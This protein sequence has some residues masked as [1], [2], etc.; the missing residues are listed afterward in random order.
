MTRPWYDLT[1]KVALVVGA[2]RGLG[3]EAALA[4]ASGGADVACA[5]RSELA[6]N[7]TVSEIEARGRRSIPL[8]LDAADERSLEAGINQVATAWGDLDVLVFAAGVMHASR[9]GDTSVSDWERV[10]RTNL[11]GAFVAARATERHMQKRGGRMIFFSTAF[12]DRALPGTLAYSV[13]KSGIR[14]LVR[15]LAVEWARYRIT[16]NAIAPGYFATDMPR[17]V[18]DTPEGREKVLSRIPARRVG[19]PSEIGPLV[20]YLASDGSSFMTGAVLTI[21]GGQSLN[22]S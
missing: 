20:H 7:A 2:S 3:K 21:D 9:A 15:S 14:Q 22:V 6:L 17:A 12:V 11:T 13:S 16:V 5:A 10:L 19:E 1:G 18:L 8:I 4:L